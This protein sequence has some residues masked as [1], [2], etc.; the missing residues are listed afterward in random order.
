[1]IIPLPTATLPADVLVAAA[2]PREMYEYTCMDRAAATRQPVC[3]SQHMAAISLPSSYTFA[4]LRSQE[5]ESKSTSSPALVTRESQ[6][7]NTRSQAKT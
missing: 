7:N 4:S 1:M 2:P 3:V 6:K 5:S